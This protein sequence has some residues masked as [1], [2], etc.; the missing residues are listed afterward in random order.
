MGALWYGWLA[1]GLGYACF[2]GVYI[3]YRSGQGTMSLLL[4]AKLLQLALYLGACAYIFH[5][6][7]V[8]FFGFFAGV[9]LFYLQYLLYWMWRGGCLW[10]QL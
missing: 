4:T 8:S 1:V 6:G 7:V 10:P 9:V 3:R 2:H 5:Q